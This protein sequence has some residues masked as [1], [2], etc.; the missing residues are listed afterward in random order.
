MTGIVFALP[1]IVGK[2]NSMDLHTLRP[3]EEEAV[4]AMIRETLQAINAA[5]YP[6][7]E[8]ETL[9]SLYQADHI[10]QLE[11]EGALYA[12]WSDDDAVCLACGALSPPKA[13]EGHCWIQGVFAR[14]NAQSKGYGKRIMAALESAAF[15]RGCQRLRLDASISARGF[16]EALGYRHLGNSSAPNESGVYP[17]EKDLHRPGQP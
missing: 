13:G 9:S 15:R 2:G 3:G 16:Y 7:E 4:S 17:M 10:R 6:Q 12:L 11:E 8:I 14:A 5:D 1:P